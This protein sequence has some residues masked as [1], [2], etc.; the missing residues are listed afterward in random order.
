[1]QSLRLWKTISFQKFQKDPRPNLWR[2]TD[3]QK[4]IANDAL[5]LEAYGTRKVE[6]P[7]NEGNIY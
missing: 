4:L 3:F 5:N 7:E 2:K 1:M 6:D